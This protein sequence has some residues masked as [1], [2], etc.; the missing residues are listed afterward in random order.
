MRADYP[1]P[2]LHT[3]PITAPHERISMTL[4]AIEATPH[5]YLAIAGAEKRAVYQQAAQGAQQQHPVS[6][7]LNS[8]KVTPHVFYHA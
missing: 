7:V 5:V 3:S 4:A 6:F 1:Q 8:Q 2:L